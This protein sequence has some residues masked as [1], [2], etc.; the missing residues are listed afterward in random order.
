MRSSVVQNIVYRNN[1]SELSEDNKGNKNTQH[2]EISSK[3]NLITE[4]CILTEYFA[5]GTRAY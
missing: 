2:I 4:N 1:Y 5:S 3:Q